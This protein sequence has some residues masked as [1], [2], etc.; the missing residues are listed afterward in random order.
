M[1]N[2]TLFI[3]ISTVIFTVIVNLIYDKITRT[4]NNR[5]L[6]RPS[7][8]RGQRT[9][10]VIVRP[11]ETS[12]NISFAGSGGSVRVHRPSN[13]ANE[14][15]QG[16]SQ[17][18]NRSSSQ[19]RIVQ[20]SNTSGNRNTRNVNTESNQ[21]NN[22]RSN[23]NEMNTIISASRTNVRSSSTSSTASRALPQM[24]RRREMSI[25]DFP[26]C[27]IHRCRNRKNDEQMIFW[28]PETSN[29]RCFYGHNFT[30]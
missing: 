15:R 17:V 16:S 8:R 10:G 4:S 24:N 12:S 2:E 20:R 30:I 9:Q 21:R 3:I 23:A 25:Y 6:P 14:N 27:P 28:N 22:A 18:S 29:Y 1:M 19:R 5:P 13:Q 11:Y 26:C 7:N